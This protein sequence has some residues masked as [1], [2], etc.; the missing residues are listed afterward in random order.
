M[1][2]DRIIAAAIALLLILGV[3]VYV[4]NTGPE[5]E[6]RGITATDISAELAAA[7]AD[8]S[9]ALNTNSRNQIRDL[10]QSAKTHISNAQASQT[11]TT[12]AVP[13]TTQAPTTTVAPTTTQAPTTTTT[14]LPPTTTTT[15]PSAC[16]GVQVAAG[17]NLVN[18]ANAHP[19]GATFCLAAGVYLGQAVVP[20]TGDRFIGAPGA[21]LRG[22]GAAFAFKSNADNVTIRGLIIEGYRPP[23]RAAVIGGVEDAFNWVIQENEIRDNGEIGISAKVGWRILGNFIHGN[24]RYGVVGS[25]ANLVV[26]GNEI[27]VNADEIGDTGD[28]GATKFV[29]T[30]LVIL[31]DNYVHHN[32]GNGLWVDINNRDA[33][34]ENNRVEFNA[35][36]GIFLEIS[37]GG[38]IRNNHV[39]G[40]GTATDNF[41]AWAGE[42]AGITVANTPNAE[43]YGN[44]L[45]GNRKGIGAIHWNHPD[46]G[47]TTKCVAELRNLNVHDNIITQSAGM[48]VGVDANTNQANVF[49]AWNNR[50]E[51]NDYDLPNTTGQWFRWAGA[52]RTWPQWQGFGHDDTGSVS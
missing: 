14:T 31:R 19:A 18:V 43:V 32:F 44:T 17:S 25:G 29:F 47:A 39:E 1:T 48:A 4:A 10:I 12:T 11:T 37:C 30:E 22:N 3:V 8:L 23:S 49:G 27:S 16:S 28:S 26:E 41:P 5:T 6:V 2:R 36:L 15:A 35:G 50:F 7:Q 20:Q 51:N 38:V 45:V 40:N 9:A 52:W 33:L 24:G 21:I 34:I 46:V 13:T 42:R